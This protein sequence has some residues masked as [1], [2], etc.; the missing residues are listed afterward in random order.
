MMPPTAQNFCAATTQQLPR[1]QTVLHHW[2]KLAQP[3]FFGKRAEKW[4]TCWYGKFGLISG[5]SETFSFLQTCPKLKKTA[6]KLLPARFG[7]RKT[8]K[9]PW[10][11]SLVHWNVTTIPQG[12]RRMRIFGRKLILRAEKSGFESWCKTTGTVTGQKHSS[13]GY[14]PKIMLC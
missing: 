11:M 5:L 10:I 6:I 4:L 1:P 7:C 2:W 13:F 12:D 3:Q 9:T 14:E 8:H